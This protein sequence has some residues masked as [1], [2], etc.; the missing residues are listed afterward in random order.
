MLKT[1]WR[2]LPIGIDYVPWSWLPDFT[3][4]VMERLIL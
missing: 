2:P 4:V 1:K 3:Q